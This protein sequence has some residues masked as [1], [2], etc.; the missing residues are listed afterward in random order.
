M[1]LA[2]PTD[3][4][5]IGKKELLNNPV[6][7][8]FFR[9]IDLPID[10]ESR[11]SAFRVFKKAQEALSRGRSILIF[12]E[13]TI[14]GGYPPRLGEFKNGPFRLALETGI[15]I[16]PVIIQDAWKLFWDDGKKLGTRPGI[17]HVDVL[18]PVTV[19]PEPIPNKTSPE[20]VLA[21]KDR[22]HSLIETRWSN[23]SDE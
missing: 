16:I 9:S 10:R 20:Q 18:R 2:C 23:R 19:H 4:S 17:V 7:G 11:L 15:P 12:P 8:L 14:H 5:F 22:I 21:L 13:G 3:F 1:V 6:T